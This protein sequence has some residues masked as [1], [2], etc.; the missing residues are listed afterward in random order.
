MRAAAKLLRDRAAELTQG[1]WNYQPGPPRA[2][3]VAEE[4]GWIIAT[5]LHIEDDDLRWMALMSPALAPLLADWLETEASCAGIGESVGKDTSDLL[6]AIAKD[7]L[8][9]KLT[10]VADTAVPALAFARA[11]LGGDA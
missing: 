2:E 3:V 1:C 7:P 5:S 11:I 9:L 8:E 6:D 10:V 4:G